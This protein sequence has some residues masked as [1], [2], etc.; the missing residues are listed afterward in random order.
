MLTFNVYIPREGPV[1]TERVAAYKPGRVLARNHIHRNLDLGL[2]A[3]KT[4]RKYISGVEVTRSV[5]F[6]LWQCKHSNTSS[7]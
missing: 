2:L 3:F 1:R 7:K 6:L 4:V 5:V